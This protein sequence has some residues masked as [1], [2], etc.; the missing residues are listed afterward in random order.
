MD[1]GNPSNFER[2]RRVFETGSLAIR[3]ML[4]GSAVTDEEI[5][6]TMRRYYEE[7]GVFLC[8]HTAAGVAASEKFIRQEMVGQG[9][10][11]TLATAHPAKFLEVFEEHVG[12]TPE[13]PERLARHLKMEKVSVKVENSVEALKRELLAR[14]R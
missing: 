14:Y 10:V 1:V 11:A 8:P 6:A 13:I 2:L 12:V 9:I 3:S 4:T 7:K 5:A